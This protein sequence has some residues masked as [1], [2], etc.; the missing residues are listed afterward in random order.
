[1]RA[2]IFDFDGLIIDTETPA[3]EAWCEIYQDNGVELKKEDWVQVVGTTYSRF[4]PVDHLN[5]LTG[6]SFDR[7][8]LTVL[9][10][11]RKAEICANMP[12][13]PGVVDRIEEAREL[14]WAIG[15]ASTSTSEWVES[16]LRRVDL[17]KFFP[18]RITRETVTN[19]KPHPEPY[20]KI[21]ERLGVQPSDSLVLEDSLNGVKA[22]KAAG[23]RCVAIP[24]S[25][26]SI[27]DF[28][29][30]DERFDSLAA[31]KLVQF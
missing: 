17:F 2:V 26:T 9:K 14:G 1:M 20:L 28:S 15:L 22:A 10:E 3:F 19:V 8:E 16:H 24:N 6:K 12:I 31:F 11:K 5:T 21:M 30:A 23:A 27:L 4:H 25:I 7:D 13:L 29:E 18:H